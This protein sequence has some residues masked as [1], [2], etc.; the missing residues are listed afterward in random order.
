MRARTLYALFFVSGTSALIYELVWQR[1]VNLV[2]GV[3]TLSVSA[4]LA[5]FMGG[6]ALGG[7]VFGRLA[8]RV[9]QPLRLY[10]CLE[11]VPGL[12]GLSMCL[13]GIAVDCVEIEAAVAR[14]AP[15]FRTENHDVRGQTAF[16]LIV[17]DARSWLQTAPNRYDV[18]VTDC[19]NIQYRSN[20]D[21]YT[22]D[23]FRLLQNLL[24]ADGIAAAW[25]PA[26]GIAERDLKTLL[27]SLGR[28]FRIP[29]SGS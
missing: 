2:L 17:D 23:Y 16:R 28:S 29:R 26:N 10:A 14:A 19:T 15:L 9:R 13:H 7:L 22:V 27:R 12:A 8:D 24:A 4:V 11:A 3:S 20:G 5:A 1:L 6:L 25:V 21:L 18:I